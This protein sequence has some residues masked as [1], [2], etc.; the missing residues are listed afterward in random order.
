MA[1]PIHTNANRNPAQIL[2]DAAPSRRTSAQKQADNAKAAAKR[3]EMEEKA[4]EIHQNGVQKIAAMEDSLRRQDRAYGTDFPRNMLETNVIEGEHTYYRDNQ[5]VNKHTTDAHEEDTDEYELTSAHS[6]SVSSELPSEEPSTHSESEDH[7]K[8]RKPKSRKKNA[9]KV[10]F[11][12]TLRFM[13]CL[14][15]TDIMIDKRQGVK[16]GSGSQQK[17]CCKRWYIGKEV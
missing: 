6:D 15:V 12:H 17:D 4:S 7:R 10:S 8:S 5:K 3:A 16:A 1:R 11:D 9:K 14:Q 2:K 13:N